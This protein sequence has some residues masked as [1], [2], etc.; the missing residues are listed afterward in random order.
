MNF[1]DLAFFFWQLASFDFPINF[2]VSTVVAKF[3]RIPGVFPL[4]PI[5]NK[6]FKIEC[7]GNKVQ[8]IVQNMKLT[9]GLESVVKDN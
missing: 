9:R 3:F 6:S 8:Q 5:A 2:C 7:C 1:L 4:N